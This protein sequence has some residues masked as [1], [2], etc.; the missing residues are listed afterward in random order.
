[1]LE[2]NERILLGAYLGEM[3]MNLRVLF[4]IETMECQS[5]YNHLD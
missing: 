1:M 3:R 2:F 5:I 4:G